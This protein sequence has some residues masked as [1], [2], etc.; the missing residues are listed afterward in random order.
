MCTYWKGRGNDR[1][2]Q[3]RERRKYLVLVK[4]CVIDTLDEGGIRSF[5]TEVMCTICR[6]NR[7][8]TITIFKREKNMYSFL[9]K[10][11]TLGE[12]GYEVNIKVIYNI[13][14]VLIVGGTGGERSP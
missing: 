8:G 1:H 6:W 7:R 13:K 10:V 2:C 12:G 5:D 3:K 4:V 9:V 14:C 11:C